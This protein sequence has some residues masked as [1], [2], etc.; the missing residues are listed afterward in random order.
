MV[1]GK[2]FFDVQAGVAA[3][4][5]K[6]LL[7]FIDC[8]TAQTKLVFTFFGGQRYHLDL[9]IAFRLAKQ[10]WICNDIYNRL[11]KVFFIQSSG[12]IFYSSV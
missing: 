9:E 6:R 10:Y 11:Y 3:P 5:F 4:T 8:S 1:N 2:I 7:D 12:E